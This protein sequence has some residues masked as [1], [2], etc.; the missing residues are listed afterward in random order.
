MESNDSPEIPDRGETTDIPGLPSGELKRLE[1]Q[2]PMHQPPVRQ[3]GSLQIL[4][5]L[6][7]CLQD[8]WLIRTGKPKTSAQPTQSQNTLLLQTTT[9]NLSCIEL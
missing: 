7:I 3:L 9:W 5:R 2:S 6:M 1:Q 8:E 4:Q